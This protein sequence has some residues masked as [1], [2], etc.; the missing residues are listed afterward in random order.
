MRCSKIVEAEF[1]DLRQ[2]ASGKRELDADTKSRDVRDFAIVDRLRSYQ[3]LPSMHNFGA[4]EP[5]FVHLVPP[6]ARENAK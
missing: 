5:S 3:H 4:L 1:R 6:D 2:C